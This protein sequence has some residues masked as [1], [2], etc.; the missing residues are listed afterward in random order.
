MAR[1]PRPAGIKRHRN[2]NYGEVAEKLNVSRGTVRHWVKSD[3]LPALTDQKPHLILG[4]D[5]YLFF[6]ARKAKRQKCT[7][8]ECYCFRCRAPR[9]PAFLVVEVRHATA[10]S[11]QMRA[12]CE[13]CSTVMHKRV[14]TAR[15]PELKRL[16]A[17][18]I[19][20]AR[21]PLNDTAE[22]CTNHHI[23]RG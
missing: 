16:V 19:K 1:H 14:S 21:R 22:P 2:Y 15:L 17:V 9:K 13:V 18:E 8:E 10:S 3:Q 11:G 12:L 4:D 20:Q 5:L 23:A 7:L 6:E